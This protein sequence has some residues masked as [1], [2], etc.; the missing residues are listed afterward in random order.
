MDWQGLLYL[1]GAGV[2]IWLIVRLVRRSPGSFTKE[3]F[4]KTAYTTGILGVILVVII[5]VV[6]MWLR[7]GY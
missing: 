5:A 2:M 7:G 4:A 6:V 1:L 3:N